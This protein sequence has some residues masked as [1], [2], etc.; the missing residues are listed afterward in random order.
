MSDSN[1]YEKVEA[2]IAY[3]ASS[4]SE[5]PSLDEIAAHVHMSPTYF[6]KVFTEWAGISPKS[7]LQYLTVDA[8][9][10][11][12][13]EH[14][15]IS[16]AA[17]Q[18][19]LSSPSRAYDHFVKIE[20]MTPGQFASLGNHLVIRYGIHPTPFGDS[21]IAITELGVCH[22]SFT[23]GLAD[24]AIARLKR[25]WPSADVHPDPIATKPVIDRIFGNQESEKAMRVVLK[26][27]PFQIKVWEALLTIPAGQLTT[28]GG[29]AEQIGHPKASRAVGSAVGD[30]PIAYLIP[31]HRV[32]RR[33]GHIGHY[34]Y[35]TTM[36]TAMIG[37]ERI[38]SDDHAADVVGQAG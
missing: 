22:V 19:G 1:A 4:V 10:S 5:Q 20:A 37:W 16:R 13:I 15:S 26:G 28:Y 23:L 7:F 12:M 29:I 38:R 32:I 36:K 31:C 34:Y 25:C 14:R 35:G 30:N 11:A 27:T 2:A 9:K 3:I 33:E 8:L 24:A 18:V 17:D 6:Q 21:L